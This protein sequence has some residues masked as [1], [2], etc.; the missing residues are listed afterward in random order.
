MRQEKPLLHDS[1]DEEKEDEEPLLLVEINIGDS[2]KHDT[3]IPLYSHSDPSKVATHYAKK[4][5]LDA[6]MTKKI[7]EELRS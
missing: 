7:E 5:G 3:K 4:H 2:N 1:H 6:V